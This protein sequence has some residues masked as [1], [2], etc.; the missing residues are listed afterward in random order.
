[1]VFLAIKISK[2]VYSVSKINWIPISK[3]M[4]LDKTIMPS[5]QI[6]TTFLV[7]RVQQFKTILKIP[8]DKIIALLE[9]TAI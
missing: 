8:L 5:I 9:I 6:I 7:N 1:M 3:T 2:Q 4:L